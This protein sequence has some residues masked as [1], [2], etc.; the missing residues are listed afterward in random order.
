MEFL[1]LSDSHGCV[2]NLQAVEARQI[3]RPDAIFFLGDGAR[4]IAYFSTQSI[5]VW[6]VRGNCDWTTTDLADKTERLLHFE[7]H[8]ILMTH[9]HE[10]G[11]KYDKELTALTKHA[12]EVGADIVLFGHTHKPFLKTLP[13]STA[14]GDITLTRPMHLF[15][16]G[17]ISYDGDRPSF[18]TLTIQGDNVLFGHGTL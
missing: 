7:G 11:V 4:D 12:A 16:P 8:S 17:S 14:W 2:E 10:W 5:P 3:K 6:A 9:G 1:I 15:N 13:T 18:G